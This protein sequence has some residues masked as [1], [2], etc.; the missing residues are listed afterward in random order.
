MYIYIYIFS[1]YL[2]CSLLKDLKDKQPC[3]HVALIG[4]SMHALSSVVNINTL[5]SLR[6]S[7]SFILLR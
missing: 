5:F 1:D 6:V 7:I 2:C 4:F 3:F